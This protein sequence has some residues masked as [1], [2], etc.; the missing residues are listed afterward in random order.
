VTFAAQ[1]KDHRAAG[2]TIASSSGA[3]SLVRGGPPQRPGE[4]SLAHNAVRF[5]D[6]LAEFPRAALEALRKPLETRHITITVA[7]CTGRRAGREL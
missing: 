5:L 2:A 6:E 7:A 4:T 1:P 3:V